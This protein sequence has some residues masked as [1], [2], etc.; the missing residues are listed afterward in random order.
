MKN[1]RFL[2]YRNIISAILLILISACEIK[3]NPE[4]VND[5]FPQAQ[6]ELQEVIK[7]IV[8]DLENA[9]IEGIN[10]HHLDSDKFTKF[11]PR[12][13]NRQDVQST[14]QSEEAFFGSVS[15]YK[16]ETKDLKI[17]V[18]G[19]VGIATYY[20]R[21]SFIQNGKEVTGNGRQTL[22]FLKTEAGWKIVH[23]HGTPKQ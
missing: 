18:F 9:N 8:S 20:P 1:I 5:T 15:D 19:N 23:E 11:G 12:N 21:V 3:S 2:N 14:N 22:V 6:S 17:D 4:V 10:S 7:S 16:L 13:F